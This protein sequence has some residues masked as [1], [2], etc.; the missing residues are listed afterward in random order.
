MSKKELIRNIASVADM[1][2]KD[3]VAV[4]EAFETVLYEAMKNGDKVMLSNIGTFTVKD[5]PERTG[6]IMMGEKTGE[7]YCVPAHQEPKFKMSKTLKDSL[8]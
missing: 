1:T 2:Q 8:L 7:T 3:V 4:L 6:T 5:I